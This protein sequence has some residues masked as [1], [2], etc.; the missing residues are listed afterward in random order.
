MSH[1]PRFVSWCLLALVV[2]G[3]VAL[4]YSALRSDRVF[5]VR[6]VVRA[7]YADGAISIQHEEIPDY[8]PA[9]TMPFLV[10]R[11]DVRDLVPGD[12]VEFEFHV[13]EHSRAKNFR[14]VDR[15]VIADERNP[16]SEAGLM[17]KASRRLR[18]GDEVPSFTLL[19]Q[20]GDRV[21][22]A[23]LRGRETILTFI[24]TRCP[25]PEFC[26]RIGR[27]FQSLQAELG[28]TSAGPRL[29][30]IS[31]DPGHDTP[32]VLR[33]YGESLGADFGRWRFATGTEEQ[34][35]ML[36]RLF[37]VRTERNGATLDHTLATA[38]IGPDG[39]V[40]EIW[41]GNAWKPEEI[42]SRR[43]TAQR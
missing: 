9:M 30:S 39:R 2:G 29:L 14:Q 3:L 31:I 41:R 35:S 43:R 17:V 8:M 36:A 38:L 15:A 16:Q 10:N 4:I 12:V 37:A 6:G 24:F 20:D 5:T 22:E 7:P 26:P 27:N 28:P 13:G 1:I 23:D 18:E 40:V 19:D 25:V 11:A 34:V 33:A 21:T 42:L 32:A